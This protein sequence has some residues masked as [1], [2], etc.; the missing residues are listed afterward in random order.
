MPCLIVLLLFPAFNA[1]RAQLTYFNTSSQFFRL[2]GG[3]GSC[4]YI[5]IDNPCGPET[6][7]LSMALYKDTMYY[8]TFQ[9][10]LKRFKLGT[11]GSC[12]EL[13]SG[14]A[15][16]NSMTIDKNGILYMASN[17]LFRYDPYTG[18]LQDLGR[19]PFA[20]GGDLIFFNSKLFLAGQDPANF[21]SGIYEINIANPS[22]SFLYMSTSPFI[23]LVS[24]PVPCTHSRY[25]GLQAGNA[26]TTMVELDLVN[27]VEKT[28][29]CIIPEIV[30]DAAST[31]EN[32]RND[33]IYI[34]GLQITA[35][36]R[37]NET[38]IVK[39]IAEY[40]TPGP[41]TYILNGNIT[42]TTGIFPDLPVGNYSITT[43][44]P[45][46]LCKKDT[47]FTIEAGANMISKIQPTNP[48][49]CFLNSGT[50][51]IESPPVSLPITY[52]LLN[53][54]QSQ[55]DGIFPG[56][57]AGIYHFHLVNAA[58]CEK[59][60]SIELIVSQN[61]FVDIIALKPA[62]CNE[63]NGE[64]KI[65]LGVDT[66]GAV[67]SINN[68]PFNGVWEYTALKGGNYYIQIKKGPDC[69]FDT[70]IIIEAK[71]FQPECNDIYVPTAFTPNNDGKNDVF[72]PWD[73]SFATDISLNIFNRWG[74]R[75]YEGRGAAVHWDGKF[76][77]VKQESGVYIYILQYTNFS[78]VKR[79]KKGT[80][81]LIR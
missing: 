41:I 13:L 60:T 32:G 3:A 20:S 9:G 1:L 34:S 79:F 66:A 59:D 27:K 5:P 69:Y 17:S 56:L 57:A 28:N 23:G 48:D 43:I 53:T 78:H 18:S 38:G 70:T 15:L 7:M 31:T 58:R 65:R 50:I 22:A 51:H 6:D 61:R 40:A 26:F 49:Q 75:V 19:L 37:A 45:N 4:N 76:K 62:R 16:F 72:M 77:G 8:N 30:L 52:T 29:T 36:C 33:D 39:I 12:E 44:A 63:D 67:S 74:Q 14:S 11:P 64:I 25:F 10:K 81:T 42:N 71:P 55:Q 2:E 21:S 24:Y 80:F 73:L 46:G 68:G 35:P 47:S 54:G